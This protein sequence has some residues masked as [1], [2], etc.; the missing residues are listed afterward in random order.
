[1]YSRDEAL[2]NV[3]TAI[4]IEGETERLNHGGKGG[5]R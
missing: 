4:Q 1:M 5:K 2:G 3:W